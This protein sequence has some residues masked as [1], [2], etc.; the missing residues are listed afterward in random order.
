MALR[1]PIRNTNGAVK[2]ATTGL[3]NQVC[4]DPEPMAGGNIASYMGILQNEDNA[5]SSFYD[6][7]ER[8]YGTDNPSGALLRLQHLAALADQDKRREA[9]RAYRKYML[10]LQD[11]HTKLVNNTG[12]FGKSDTANI[13]KELA[14]P[15]S[16]MAD[17]INTLQKD[18]R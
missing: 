17:A 7:I 18:A 10:A 11:A 5:I 12:T 9:A 8:K 15:L 1:F 14:Q 16:D 4:P 13:A 6:V 3:A 2:I